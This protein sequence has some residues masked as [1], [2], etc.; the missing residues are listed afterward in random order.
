ML[1]STL[2]ALDTTTG[3][4]TQTGG[5]PTADGPDGRPRYGVSVSYAP[6]PDCGE[7][8][9]AYDPATGESR[10]AACGTRGG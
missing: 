7:G 1:V 2:A 10:C 8:A 5:D 3:D 6:C 4:E 9:L